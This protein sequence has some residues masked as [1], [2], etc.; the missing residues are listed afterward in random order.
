MKKPNDPSSVPGQ[1]VKEVSYTKYYILTVIG[2]LLT[3]YPVYFLFDIDTIE[4]IGRE[5]HFF[6]WGTAIFLLIASIFFFLVF[7]TT[8]N[9]WVLMLGLMMFIGFGE[10]ISWG[11]RIL[12]FSTPEALKEINVQ[13]ET[14][15]H[16][17]RVFQRS[18]REGNT[19][20]GLGRLTE[21]QFLFKV[22]TMFFGILLPLIVFH[23]KFFSRISQSIKI[24]VPPV[25]IGIFF[26]ISWLVYKTMETFVL[27]NDQHAQYYDTIYEIMEY[28]A[29]FVLMTISYYFYQNRYAHPMGRDIKQI[30]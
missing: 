6:E 28:V 15:F 5:D 13:E 4:T 27:L 11:Q 10:E 30:I 18:D 20:D 14:T 21:I 29:A 24:P 16:N 25:S 1:Y 19:K 12:G 8:R 22:F 7:R 3:S 2:I 23:F 9:Y 17:I 26:F